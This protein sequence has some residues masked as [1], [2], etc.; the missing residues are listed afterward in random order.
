M[1]RIVIIISIVAIIIGSYTTK[2]INY[3]SL[4]GDLR[5][6]VTSKDSI[7]SDLK[8]TVSDS[9]ANVL[10]LSNTIAGLEANIELLTTSSKELTKELTI[11]KN[12]E[13][14]IKYKYIYKKIYVDSNLTRGDISSGDCET[15]LDLN[16][17]IGEIK[18]EDL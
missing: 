9:E 7:I 18:Y 6:S 13:P 1:K 11:W 5:T 14:I 16:R 8:R 15:G 12:K 2:L 4:V 10:I 17:A 3:E